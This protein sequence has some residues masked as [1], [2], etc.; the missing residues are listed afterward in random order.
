MHVPGGTVVSTK[1]KT[2][3]LQFCPI[4]LIA[5][6]KGFKSTSNE[7]KLPLLSESFCTSKLIST[8]ITLA[9]EYADTS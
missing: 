1:I 4:V 5:F 6:L 2:S 9:Y 8:I 3:S 7:F